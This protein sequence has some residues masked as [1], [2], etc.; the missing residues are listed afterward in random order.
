MKKFKGPNCDQRVRGISG[1][2]RKQR[3]RERGREAGRQGGR[4]GERDKD[5]RTT[6]IVVGSEASGADWL[7]SVA[8]SVPKERRR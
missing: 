1:R 6:D 5:R 8:L 2:E 3:E 4:E 7:N